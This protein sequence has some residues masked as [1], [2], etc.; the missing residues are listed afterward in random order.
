MAL[1]VCPYCS[2]EIDADEM[3]AMVLRNKKTNVANGMEAFCTHCYWK[4][5]V[6]SADDDDEPAEVCETEPAE[7]ETA[8]T[9]PT[10]TDAPRKE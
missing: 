2:M 7:K 10:E 4:Q 5:S 1:C 8:A 9:P 6:M 3:K